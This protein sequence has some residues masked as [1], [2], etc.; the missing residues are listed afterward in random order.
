MPSEK[1]STPTAVA[2]C[3]GEKLMIGE[4]HFLRRVEGLDAGGKQ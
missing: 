3:E 2:E 4:V 1:F